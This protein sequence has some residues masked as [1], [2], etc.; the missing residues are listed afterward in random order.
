MQFHCVEISMF[1]H[2]LHFCGFSSGPQ[3]FW[4]TQ[5]MLLAFCWRFG[6]WLELLKVKLVGWLG[7]CWFRVHMQLTFALL[8]IS[9]SRMWETFMLTTLLISPHSPFLFIQFGLKMPKKTFVVVRRGQVDV[10]ISCRCCRCCCISM[11]CCVASYVHTLIFH[12]SI[13]LTMV[14]PKFSPLL[15]WKLSFNWFINS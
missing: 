1:V 15:L 3:N 6:D 9:C 7:G 10:Y 8:S 13:S 5:Q 4:R 14:K 2:K 12:Q 11:S